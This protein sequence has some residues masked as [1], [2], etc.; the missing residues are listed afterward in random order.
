M[1]LRKAEIVPTSVFPQY[2]TLFHELDVQDIVAHEAVIRTGKRRWPANQLRE[3]Q[4][5][6][7][8]SSLGGEVCVQ[9]WR[10]P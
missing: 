7:W 8:I 1:P 9:D 5:R 10:R 4:E 3:A 6:K 2:P